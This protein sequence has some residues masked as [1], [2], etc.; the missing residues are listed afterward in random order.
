MGQSLIQLIQAIRPLYIGTISNL[1]SFL[2]ESRLTRS[3][4]KNYSLP[5]LWYDA[6]RIEIDA[7]SNSSLPWERVYRVIGW[8]RKGD[9]QEDSQ[10]PL[11]YDT[12]LIEQFSIFA[13]IPYH[14]KVSSE[15]LP[16]NDMR[17]THTDTE[18]DEKDLWITPLRWAHVTWY[19]YQVS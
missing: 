8:Q 14:G 16:S 11:W 6:D 10:S 5:F 17:D 7:S 1:I 2:Q 4:G 18:T 3:S 13:C 15:L 19:T 12:Y 9:S